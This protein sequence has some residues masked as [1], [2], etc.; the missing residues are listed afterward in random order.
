MKRMVYIIIAVA[1]IAITGAI[2]AGCAV[3]PT[4]NNESKVI[5]GVSLSQ[6]H[7]DFYY[8][9]S[10]YLR[11]DSGKILLDADVRFDEEP[12]EVILE[13]CEA[14]KA[15]FQNLLSIIEKYNVEDYVNKYK[16]KPLPFEA[17]DKTTMK[18]TLY[19]TDGSDKSADTGEDY[20][21]ELYDFFK[22]LA[23]DYHSKAVSANF[24]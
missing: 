7:S 13:G 6:Q 19:Y 23:L 20:R 5:S 10:F 24:E 4:K 17:M 15:D 3:N 16:K 18:T 14:E 9:Y 12:Y 2:V 21:Q 22:K 8:Y 1:A 11:E